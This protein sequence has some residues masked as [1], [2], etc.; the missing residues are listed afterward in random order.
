M[1]IG[2][3]TRRPSSWASSALIRAFRSL[4][5]RVIPLRFRDVVAFIDR[6]RLKV[7]VKG[8]DLIS[9]VAAV[10]VRPFGRVSLDQAVLRLDLLYALHEHG[11]SVFNEPMAI[12]KCVDKFRALY[13]LKLHGIPVPRTLVAER[14]SLALRSLD[15][16]KSRHIV[17]KPMF[18]SRGHGATRV[19]I[20]D[21]EVLW[22]IARSLA[23]TRHTIYLQEYIE[24]GGADIRVFVLGDKVLAAM[25]RKAPS[26]S[27]KTNIARGGR[28][29]R[30]ERLEPEIEEIALKAT[31]I[32]GCEIAGVDLVREGES[33]S[34]LEVNSQPGW[35]GLQ[36]VCPDIDIALE[37]AKYV[38]EHTR[39]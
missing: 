10:V 6:D 37:I 12:E 24:H 26:S 13:T 30:I 32:L 22:E 9:E 27:W 20:S 8:M 38:V 34:V 3:F 11:I 36:S 21:R 23:F 35:H 39:K 15:M 17:V 7:F 18:G 29:E 25:Y 33:V 31:S 2:I 19:K 1:N 4:G 14:S 28:P 5:H 16:I